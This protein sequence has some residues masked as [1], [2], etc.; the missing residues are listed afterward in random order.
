MLFALFFFFFFFR[1]RNEREIVEI[2]ALSD[3]VAWLWLE[4]DPLIAMNTAKKRIN[5]FLSIA[6]DNTITSDVPNLD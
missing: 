4:F 1:T 5:P 3:V 6:F 2:T